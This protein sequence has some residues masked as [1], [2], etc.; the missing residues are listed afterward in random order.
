MVVLPVCVESALVGSLLEESEFLGAQ[1]R[2][3]YFRL[4]SSTMALIDLTKQ[5][6]PQHGGEGE[7]KQADGHELGAQPGP[8]HSAEGGLR[9][10]GLV[11]NLSHPA[12]VAASQRAVGG[13]KGGN[14]DQCVQG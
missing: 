12:H 9:Q 5:V 8:H 14:D 7:E 3:R 4:S 13:V 11:Q 10:V 6:P 1:S 2:W